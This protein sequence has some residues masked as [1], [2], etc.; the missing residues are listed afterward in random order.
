[1]TCRRISLLHVVRLSEVSRLRRVPPGG[2]GA[3][4][5][6]R[7]QVPSQRLGC[8]NRSLFGPQDGPSLGPNFEL[9]PEDARKT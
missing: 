3:D 6:V 5:I 7:E 1:M 4:H 2:S 9:G 8:I